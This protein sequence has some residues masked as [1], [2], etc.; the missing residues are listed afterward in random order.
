MMVIHMRLAEL[1]TIQKKRELSE[2]ELEEMKHC[3]QLNADYAYRLADLYNFALIAN[4]TEDMDYLH[5]I[6]CQIDKL[7]LEYKLKKPTLRE[8]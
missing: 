8:R 3:L 4:M 1:W 6:C 5:E 2:F 7:E